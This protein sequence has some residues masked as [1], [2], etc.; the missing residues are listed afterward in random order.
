MHNLLAS[1]K[2]INN[3]FQLG[4]NCTAIHASGYHAVESQRGYLETS[5]QF[6]PDHNKLKKIVESS[7]IALV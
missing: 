1:F 7:V 3:Y 5:L 4:L 6:Q 2:K